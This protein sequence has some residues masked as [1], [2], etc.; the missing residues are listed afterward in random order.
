MDMDLGRRVE[1]GWRNWGIRNSGSRFLGEHPWSAILVGELG[2]FAG[3]SLAVRWV[4]F[5][6]SRQYSDPQRLVEIR[7]QLGRMDLG[8]RIGDG[9]R[10]RDVGDPGD[11][12]PR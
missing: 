1:R 3:E 5:G 9:W 11:C 12:R 6:L 10:N 8:W 4:R 2:G 7:C